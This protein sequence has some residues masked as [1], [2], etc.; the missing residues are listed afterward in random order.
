MGIVTFIV[1]GLSSWWQLPLDFMVDLVPQSCGVYIPYPGATPSQVEEEIAIPAEGLFKSIPGLE[2]I[3]TQSDSGG[4]NIW[5][6]FSYNQAPAL[7]SAEVR[8]RIERLKLVIPQEIEHIY[9]RRFEPNALPILQLALFRDERQDELAQYAR[10]T[11]RSRLLRIDGIADVQVSGL[12]QESVYVHF[13]QDALIRHRLSIYEVVSALQAQSV[14]VGV[15]ELTGGRQ[16]SYVRALDEFATGHD[17]E[18]VV[19]SPTGIRLRDVAEVDV[20]GPSGADYFTIDGKRGVFI[21]VVKDAEANTVEASR[22]VR[23]ELERLNELDEFE[24]ADYLVFQDHAEIIELA[25]SSLYGV[26]AYGSLMAFLVLWLFLRKTRITLVVALAIPISLLVAPIFIYFTGRSLNLITIGAMLISLG[27][28]VDNAIVVVENIHRHEL[29]GRSPLE[30]ARRGASEVGLA[31]T[32]ATLTTLVVFLPLFYMP[33][34]ELSTIME[35]FAGPIS[36]ALTMS[37][38]MALTVL[39]VAQR[40]TART[41]Q[42]ERKSTG[43]RGRLS[44]FSQTLRLGTHL[45]DGYEHLLAWGLRWRFAVILC[46]LALVVV[47]MTVP[48]PRTGFKGMPEIDLRILHVRFSADPNYGYESAVATVDALTARIDA[49]REA[50]GIRNLYVHSGSWGGQISVHLY[51]KGETPTPDGGL[52]DTQ[53]VRERIAALLPERVPGGQIDC[54]MP[55]TNPE[56]GSTV[57]VRFRG[58]DSATLRGLADTFMAQMRLLPELRN[59]ASSM[60][61]DREEIQLEI[62]EVRAADAGMSPLSIARSV[63]FALRGTALPNL[64]REGREIRVH[65]QLAIADRGTTNDLERMALPGTGGAMLSLAQ[66]V[67]MQKG[68]T[69]PAISRSDARSYLEIQGRME[70]E[71]MLQVRAALQRLITEFSTPPGYTV[72]IDENLRAIDETLDEFNKTLIMAIALIYL[73]LAALFESWLLPLSVVATVPLAYVGVYWVLYLTGTPLDTISM[74][75]SVFLCGVIVNNGIVIVDHINALRRDGLE[76]REAVLQGGKNRLRPVLMT[77]LTTIL[78]VLPLA[79]G[80][81]AGGALDALGRTLVGGL[82]VGSTL[83]IFVVPL[84]YTLFDDLQ[85]WTANYFGSLARLGKGTP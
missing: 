56:G 67:D 27:M 49:Q 11:L 68:E 20:Q 1:I 3:H 23:A 17:L 65:G 45:Q 61:E 44:N 19:I 78:S 57:R 62:D 10:T 30:A 8:D 75:G 55:T 38:L 31:I 83:T 66:L 50:L 22:R 82:T 42:P 70:N 63:D 77:S 12:D 39:P 64:K 69:P 51:K 58:Q 41:T 81:A 47:T 2:R 34:G 85:T 25:V 72:E 52:L 54:G 53:E 59:V 13:E 16:A 74:V 7:V 76:R 46:A 6:R 5:M 80:G 15:G 79:F 4:C 60:P 40:L 71:D 37:L 48:Y 29:L 35:E 33:A 32:A 73:L 18:N 14:N 26:G 43:W 28:L 24:G 36:A 9:L 84:I 21:S